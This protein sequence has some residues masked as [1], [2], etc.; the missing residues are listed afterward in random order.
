[1]RREYLVAKR[2]NHWGIFTATRYHGP[3]MSRQAAR[4]SAIKMAKHDLT[5]GFAAIVTLDNEGAMETI[6]DSEE[7]SLSAADKA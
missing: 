6:Y 5:A 4:D 1:M 7:S 3:Y 2:A